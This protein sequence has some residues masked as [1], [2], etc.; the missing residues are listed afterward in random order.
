MKVEEAAAHAPARAVRAG[1][2]TRTGR[3]RICGERANEKLPPA[4]DLVEPMRREPRHRITVRP[5][6]HPP[7]GE[8][9]RPANFRGD[10][11]R[12]ILVAIEWCLR[13]GPDPGPPPPPCPGTGL[14]VVLAVQRTRPVSQAGVW[15]VAS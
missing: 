2:L 13:P 4:F 12:L 15:L 5:A 3:P 8:V 1:V 6:R 7:V 14:A 11:R 10:R 9:T